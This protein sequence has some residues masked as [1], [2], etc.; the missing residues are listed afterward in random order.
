[1]VT[2]VWGTSFPVLDLLVQDLTRKA[3]TSTKIPPRNTSHITV[4]LDVKTNP[5]SLHQ[6]ERISK[7]IFIARKTRFVSLAKWRDVVSSCRVSNVFSRPLNERWLHRQASPTAAERDVRG[8]HS[9]VLAYPHYCILSRKTKLLPKMSISFNGMKSGGGR[10][11]MTAN[12]THPSQLLHPLIE[13]GAFEILAWPTGNTAICV[14]NCLKLFS[15]WWY[16]RSYF[17]FFFFF[18]YQRA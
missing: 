9:I 2:K 5:R 14:V 4:S 7:P 3:L 17:N 11:Q 13:F 16:I 10:W 1:M 12:T 8:G 6:D 18:F 15:C